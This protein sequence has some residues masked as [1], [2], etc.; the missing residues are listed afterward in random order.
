MSTCT[1]ATDSFS[2]SAGIGDSTY[3]YFPWA[4]L[5]SVYRPYEPLAGPG[6]APVAVFTD[7]NGV[8]RRQV[9]LVDASGQPLTGQ[10]T[11]ATGTLGETTSDLSACW[12]WVGG[13]WA[14]GWCPC[15]CLCVVCAGV[16]KE[17]AE[18]RARELAQSECDCSLAVNLLRCA[19]AFEHPCG[20]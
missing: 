1:V 14:A 7:E 5:V 8:I 11:G 20:A 2:V 12:A 16:Y 15:V 6:R 19:A 4:V 13:G 9:V 18:G 3:G 17:G 10:V